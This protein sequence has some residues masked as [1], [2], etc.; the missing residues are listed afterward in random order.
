MKSR[1]TFACLLAVSLFAVDSLVAQQAKSDSDQSR[2]FEFWVGNWKTEM[3][4]YP[5]WE[6]K[7]GRDQ[8]RSHLNG[9]LI[10]EVF[11]KG[12]QG[13]NFQRGYLFYLQREKRWQ[14]IIYDVNWGEYKFYGQRK[15]DR[16]VLTSL[17]DDTRPGSRRETFY[18]I[19]ENS[20]DY[21]WEES[22]DNGKTWKAFWRVKYR[23][24]IEPTA[25]G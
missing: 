4:N 3:T 21:L 9:R 2:A 14:H 7:K 18:N 5:K 19:K 6:K 11:F 13:E 24:V 22:H 15:G 23:R 8:V 17:K 12:N 16:I 25:K 20:F 10:E 1:L